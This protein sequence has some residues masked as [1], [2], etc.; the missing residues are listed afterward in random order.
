MLA[1]AL[2]VPAAAFAFGFALAPAA[3]AEA[4]WSVEA[5]VPFAGALA[6]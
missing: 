1:G 3:E 2:V 5:A 6:L 4:F